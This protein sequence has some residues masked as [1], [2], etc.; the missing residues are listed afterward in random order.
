MSS[1]YDISLSK[2]SS[3]L[4]SSAAT[5]MS[6]TTTTKPYGILNDTLPMMLVSQVTPVSI[7]NKPKT[8]TRERKSVIFVFSYFK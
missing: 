4:S 8:K 7:Q 2:D 1:E 5:I 3:P 6:T